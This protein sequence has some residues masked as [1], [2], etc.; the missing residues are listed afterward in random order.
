MIASLDHECGCWDFWKYRGLGR[1]SGG[2]QPSLAPKCSRD[3]SLST[4]IPGGFGNQVSWQRLVESGEAGPLQSSICWVCLKS[5]C[6]GF[7][8][9]RDLLPIWYFTL[10]SLFALVLYLRLHTCPCFLNIFRCTA[11]QGATHLLS[12][13]ELTHILLVVSW[14]CNSLLQCQGPQ[15]KEPQTSLAAWVSLGL[16]IK[17]SHLE[18]RQLNC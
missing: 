10:V 5:S 6:Q 8:S 12:A 4:S 7:C 18:G 3:K 2:R 13:M 1:W 14:R 9:G 11:L 17:A 16:K 15:K